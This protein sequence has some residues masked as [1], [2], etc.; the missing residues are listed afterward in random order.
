ML[1][2]MSISHPYFPEDVVISGK[3]FTENTLTV[4][5]LILTFAAGCTLL[6]ITTLLVVRH[7]N[8]ALKLTDL[9]KVLWFVLSEPSTYVCNITHSNELVAGS[10]H[11]FFEGYFVYN[12]SRMSSMQ[13]FFGQLWKEY[14]LSDSRYMSSDPLVLCMESLTVV[15]TFNSLTS[16]SS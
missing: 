16:Q 6:L 15:R 14:A 10:I 9:W 8:A 1:H 2:T 12:H 11:V 3:T 13:D 5:T 4:P 7:A